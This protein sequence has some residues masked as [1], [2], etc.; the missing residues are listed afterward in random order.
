MKEGRRPD[1][2]K[3]PLTGVRAQDLTASANNLRQKTSDEVKSPRR[4]EVLPQLKE[5]NKL[6]GSK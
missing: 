6:I 2:K 1:I 5:P 3:R 4:N